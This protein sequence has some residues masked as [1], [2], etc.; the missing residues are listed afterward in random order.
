MRI[1]RMQ[2]EYNL[3]MGEC[4]MELGNI[5]DAIIH[6][7]NVVK[8]KPRG[9]S[10]WEA[11]I[12]CLYKE[13]FWA[14]ATEQIDNAQRIAGDKPLFLFYK[15][16]VLFAE[17]KSKEALLLLQSAMER[18]QRLLRKFIELNPVILQSSR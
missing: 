3:A 15:S 9:I 16:A 7:S 14:E 18:A 10:G 17:G 11:L 1:H 4:L 13:G 12:R 6:F 2:P 8:A 5:K